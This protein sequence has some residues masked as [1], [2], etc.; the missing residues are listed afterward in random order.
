MKPIK[1]VT[2]DLGR[3]RCADAEP[4]GARRTRRRACR[5]RGFGPRPVCANR[6][7]RRAARRRACAHLAPAAARDLPERQAARQTIRHRPA[8][9]RAAADQRLRHLWLC[10]GLQPDL[11][12]RAAV[13]ARSCHHGGSRGP[14]DQL[15]DRRGTTAILRSHG[16]D[17]LGDLLP[18]A[19]EFWRS[20]MT[21]AVQPCAGIAIPEQADGLSLSGARTLAQLRAAC[22]T[23]R[24]TSMLTAWNGISMPRCSICP[25]RTPT[26]SRRRS[27][28]RF[29]MWS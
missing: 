21:V 15:P 2:P 5:G 20:S 28:N 10:D 27:A 29:A 13:F 22:S 1:L 25:V 3:P 6:R 19:A 9:R 16:L 7:R 4:R 18:F 8:G 12:R 24:S 17:T 11:R 26:R 14:P 23:A